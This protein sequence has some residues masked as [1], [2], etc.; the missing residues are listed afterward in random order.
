MTKSI[1]EKKLE[2]LEFSQGYATENY[3]HARVVNLSLKESIEE[4][5]RRKEC[6][7]GYPHLCTKTP[8]NCDFKVNWLDIE[9][10]FGKIEDDKKEN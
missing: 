10:I 6:C 1:F 7:V 3:I 4:L 2:G 5:N 8:E 9:E